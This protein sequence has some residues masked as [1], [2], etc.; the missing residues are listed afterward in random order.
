MFFIKE[1]NI[2]PISFA[3]GYEKLMMNLVIKFV[4]QKFNY[5]SISQ[6]LFIDEGLDCI[7]TNNIKVFSNLMCDTNEQ[8]TTFLITH[9][10]RFQELSTETIKVNHDKINGSFI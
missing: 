3:S 9:S 2:H 4:L 7:D 5:N 1:E 8:R 6:I 10:K